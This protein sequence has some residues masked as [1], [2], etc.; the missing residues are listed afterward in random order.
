[1]TS[2]A[3]WPRAEPLATTRLRL[4]PLRAGHAE[5]AF[6]MLNDERLHRWT[7]DRPAPSIDQLADRYRRQSAGRSADGTRGWLNWMLRRDADGQLVGTV[8]ATLHRPVP[9]RLEA[10]LAWVVGTEHQ[11]NGYGREAAQA[12]VSS[13]R[14]HGVGIF[15]AHVHPEHT[16]SNRIARALGLTPTDTV[17]G[18]ELRWSGSGSG[19]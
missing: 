13:L 3:S 18:G 11:G 8:Q 7:G 9:A 2:T 4:E 10:E 16:A 19:R 12:M 14:G 1:M 6:A 17:V 5:E 15:A